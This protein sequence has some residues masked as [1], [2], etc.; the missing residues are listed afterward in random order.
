MI[1][2][3]TELQSIKPFVYPSPLPGFEMVRGYGVVCLPFDTGHVLALRFFPQNDFTPYTTIWHRTPEGL[4][5]IFVDGP[6]LDAACPRYFSAAAARCLRAH[7]SLSWLAA[8]RL[9]VQM[10]SPRFLWTLTLA[11]PRLFRF[12][13]EIVSHTPESI[14]R[15]LRVLR[16]MEWRAG[17]SSRWARFR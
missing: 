12:M 8:M 6:R 4:W 13:N 5:S 7:I 3:A 14:L 2:L 11:E 16:F 10:D 15:T 9:S 17:Q 1:V